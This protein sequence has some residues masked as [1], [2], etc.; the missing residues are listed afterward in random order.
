[1]H[2]LGFVCFFPSLMA[3]HEHLMEHP[4]QAALPAAQTSLEL[5]KVPGGSS[6]TANKGPLM[7]LA[8][9]HKGGPFAPLGAHRANLLLHILML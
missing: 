9:W 6:H 1:M 5:G 2:P 7:K 8:A 4:H 3:W